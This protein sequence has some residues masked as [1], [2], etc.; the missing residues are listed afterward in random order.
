LEKEGDLR[1]REAVIGNDLDDQSPSETGTS[2]SARKNACLFC[3]AT[4]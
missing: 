4:T 1:R 3:A 2:Q